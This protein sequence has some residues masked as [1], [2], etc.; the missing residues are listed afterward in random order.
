ML[1]CSI[2]LSQLVGRAQLK[3]RSRSLTV[4]FEAYSILLFECHMRVRNDLRECPG[5]C[6]QLVYRTSDE[7]TSAVFR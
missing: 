7:A 6:M 2:R 4:P 3:R 5:L 1:S